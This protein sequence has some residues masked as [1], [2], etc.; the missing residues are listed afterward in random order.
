MQSMYF[1]ADLQTQALN[2]VDNDFLIMLSWPFDFEKS[3]SN[4]AWFSQPMMYLK[5]A[6]ERK[7]SVFLSHTHQGNSKRW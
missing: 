1:S 4:F 5:I 7:S 2:L 6:E 3:N